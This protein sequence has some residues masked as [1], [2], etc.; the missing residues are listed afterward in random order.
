MQSTFEICLWICISLFVVDEKPTDLIS[1]VN[2]VF[3]SGCA[4]LYI[5]F[6]VKLS[7]ISFQRGHIITT[8]S[9]M[10]KYGTM[11]DGIDTSSMGKRMYYPLLLVKKV[12]CL[13]Q[14]PQRLE[15]I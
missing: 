1:I 13:H 6:V 15:E 7:Y 11:F 2:T 10:A 8:P 9:N 4:G 14:P 5:S 12:A 3:T